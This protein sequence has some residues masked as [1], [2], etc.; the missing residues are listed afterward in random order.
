MLLEEGVCYDQCIFVAKLLASALL[1]FVL[2]GRAC[3]LLQVSLDF[4]LLHPVPHEE[5][6]IFFFGVSSR[7]SCRSSQNHSTSASSALAVGAET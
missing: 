1:R 3:L 4:L 7:R 6:D 2:Q 5:K